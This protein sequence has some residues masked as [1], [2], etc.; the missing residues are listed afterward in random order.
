MT[1]ISMAERIRWQM[2]AASLLTQL[3]LR[4]AGAGLPAVA[5]TVAP[6]GSGLHGSCLVTE[7]REGQRREH[8]EAWRAAV[9]AASGREPDDDR[10]TTTP[11]GETR[12][13]AQ[14]R[15]VPLRP[16]TRCPAVRVTL[17]AS[18]WPADDEE[19]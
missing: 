7:T 11:G 18:I 19:S 15:E 4:A 5:W 14:W 10:E 16:G 2:Q 1:E 8:F 6:A 13:A 3:L 9:T 17:T 12:L